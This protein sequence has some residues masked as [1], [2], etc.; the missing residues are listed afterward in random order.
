MLLAWQRGFGSGDIGSFFFWTLPL[1][2]GVAAAGPVVLRLLERVPASG[3]WL[4]LLGAVLLGAF[5]WLRVVLWA[6]GPWGGAFSFPLVYPW[7]I[8]VAA[9][10]FFQNRFLLHDPEKV[11]SWRYLLTNLLLVP[12][13]LLVLGGGSW[14]RSYFNQPMPETY[15]IPANFRG[16]MRIV[17][18]EKGGVN[19]PLENGRLVLKIPAD[20]ILLIQP[21]FRSGAQDT[22]FYL[23]DEAGREE[24][25]FD[26]T[27]VGE[28]SKVRPHVRTESIK[29]IAGYMPD[30]SAST[31]SP[32]AITY[33]TYTVY[34]PGAPV[35]SKDMLLRQQERQDS[36]MMGH[37]ERSRLL[38]PQ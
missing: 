9:Q 7:L 11:V 32:L 5:G 34:D 15:L 37:I 12:G 4:L 35:E 28:P 31:D 18:K 14:L 6:L 23:V 21:E 8:G 27:Q 33:V 22:K 38:R 25:L 19:P 17:Y 16:T 10:L 36:L 24:R 26:D 3:R 2:M 30:G 29:G 13:V 20:G 1:A